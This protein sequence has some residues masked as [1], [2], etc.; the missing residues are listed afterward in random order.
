MRT[1][2]QTP[3]LPSGPVIRLDAATVLLQWAAGGMAF[4]LVH[5]QAPE[6]GLGYGWLL[7]GIYLVMAARRRSPPASPSAPCRSGRRRRSGSPLACLLGSACR[8]PGGGLASP[9]SAPSTTAA[10]NASRR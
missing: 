7:R 1:V 8:S 6:V 5:D 3:P 10:A 4:L 2:T 9:A